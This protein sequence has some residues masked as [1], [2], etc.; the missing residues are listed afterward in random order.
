MNSLS[1]GTRNAHSQ[2]RISL[3][4]HSMHYYWTRPYS[5]CLVARS[6]LTLCDPT[7]CSTLVQPV[8][9]HLPKFA[10][11]H[12]YCIG[13]AIQPSH[14]QTPSSPSV[15]NLSQLQGLFQ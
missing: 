7:D 12:V 11:V 5:C 9:H 1:P 2:V 4:G 13:D 6:C 8:L 3:I 15:L 10:Q 14:P